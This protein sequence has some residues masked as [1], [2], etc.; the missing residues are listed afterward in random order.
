MDN[1]WVIYKRHSH[2]WLESQGSL[3]EVVA[4][5]TRGLWSLCRVAVVDGAELH[6]PSW[7]SLGR[8]TIGVDSWAS[9][10]V[11]ARRGLFTARAE[12]C[13]AQTS[14][15]LCAD[16][17]ALWHPQLA[18]ACSAALSLPSPAFFTFFPAFSAAYNLSFFQGVALL[19]PFL[20]FG[21]QNSLSLLVF[22]FL[23]GALL[24]LKGLL[25]NPAVFM[26]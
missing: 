1:W 11:L 5:G 19:L 10:T 20:F 21:A 12:T 3:S 9:F 15:L 18:R 2:G 8:H 16:L 17:P 22:A 4:G 7:R 23:S 24:C 26:N 14:Q 6:V 25:W 13:R